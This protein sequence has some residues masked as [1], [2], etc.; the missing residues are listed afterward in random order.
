MHSAETLTGENEPANTAKGV[1]RNDEEKWRDLQDL[2]DELLHF[3]QMKKK[4]IS[5]ERS[6]Y[7]EFN[8]LAL[9]MHHNHK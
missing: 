7:L 3:M 5:T 4:S 2:I 1:R 8:L 6:N 9:H